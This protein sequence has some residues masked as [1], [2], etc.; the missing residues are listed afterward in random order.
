M[1]VILFG[2]SGMVGQG[3]LRE[4]L[5]DP[6][7]TQVISVVRRKSVQQHDLVHADFFDFAPV[8]AQLAGADA[9]FFCLGATSV[10][11]TEPEYRRITYDITVAAATTLQRVNPG[12]TFIFVSGKSSDSTEK[13]S[14]MWAR[15]K[16][17]AENAV[18]RMFAKGYAFRPGVIEPLHGITSRTRTYRIGYLFIRPLMPLLRLWKSQVTNT[19]QIGRAMLSV[20]KHGYA[21]RILESADINR[22]V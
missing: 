14:V 4:C 7:V 21:K 10:G 1:K 22:V 17:A 12:M 11:L 3:V 20:A 8:E 2:G 18:L 6:D 19:E 9:C 16:G 15:V 5:L 13:G